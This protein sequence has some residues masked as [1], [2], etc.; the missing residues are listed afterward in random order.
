MDTM[1]WGVVYPTLEVLPQ[2]LEGRSGNI[3]N[4]TSIA[5]RMSVPHLLPYCCAKFAAVGFSE[6]LRAELG[7]EN[8]KVTT[9]LPGLMRTG[10][11]KNAEMK[12]NFQAEYSWFAL[13]STTPLT[14]ISAAGA[15][16][17][18]ALAV[19]MGEADVVLTPQAKLAALAHGVAPGLTADVLGVA[20]RFLPK[21]AGSPTER[22]F[23]RDI[24]APLADSFITTL[25]ERAADK[26]QHRA[27]ER[28]KPS[29]HPAILRGPAEFAS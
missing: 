6:G 21:P 12:G 24:D 28:E 7:K 11:Y 23:G 15:A 4:I 8:I 3:V 19:R 1:F 20:N 27:Q 14:T 25:G 26:Y 18:I 2:M 10:S 16:R 5:G 29:V 22:R 9:V 17:R 13:S